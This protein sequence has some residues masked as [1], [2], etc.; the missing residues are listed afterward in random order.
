ME[1]FLSHGSQCQDQGLLEGVRWHL[2]Y[3]ERWQETCQPNKETLNSNLW[4]EEK[5]S[6][7]IIKALVKY[8]MMED[9]RCV[10]ETKR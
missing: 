8:D 1:V 7:K 5:K 2:T 6:S 4:K 10:M 3:T 9:S